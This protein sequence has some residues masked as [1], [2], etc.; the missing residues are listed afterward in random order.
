MTEATSPRRDAPLTKEQQELVTEALA[1][2]VVLAAKLGQRWADRLSE[3][4]VQAAAAAALVEAA[5]TYDPSQGVPF[6]M[7]GSFRVQK[8]ILDLGRAELRRSKAFLALSAHSVAR[9]YLAEQPDIPKD[10][11]GNSTSDWRRRSST[12]GGG[13]VAAAFAGMVAD[14]LN[15]QDGTEEALAR[16]QDYERAV[17]AIQD[18]RRYLVERER[19]VLDLRYGQ[20]LKLEEVAA[21]M[22]IAYSTAKRI[23][24]AML[25]HL[26][27]FLRARGV[28]GLE[29]AGMTG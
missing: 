29:D 4:E 15:T 11:E 5:R 26:E 28:S 24:A 21:Q 1:S 25:I 20:E 13:V 17:A 19:V 3:D 9:G 12:F 10:D 27:G 23:H 16:K 6:K 7:Y 18:A 8:S 2:I 22:G 14:V